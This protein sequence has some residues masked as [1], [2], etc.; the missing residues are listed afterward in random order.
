MLLLRNVEACMPNQSIHVTVWHWEYFCSILVHRLRG[1]F[2]RSSRCIN[3]SSSHSCYHI[4][5]CKPYACDGCDPVGPFRAMASCDVRL[6]ELLEHVIIAFKLACVLAVRQQRWK[7]HD[8]A[9][10]WL[11]K[12]KK[13]SFPNLCKL[14]T[15][16]ALLTDMHYLLIESQSQVLLLDEGTHN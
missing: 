12:P 2:S 9:C 6:I 4:A 7:I 1:N 8:S 11:T 14:R 16:A 13:R 15:K 5:N 3:F 10:C